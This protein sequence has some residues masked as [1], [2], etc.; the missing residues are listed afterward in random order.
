MGNYFIK[1]ERYVT[2]MMKRVPFVMSEDE[3]EGRLREHFHKEWLPGST[4]P[5]SDAWDD[6]VDNHILSGKEWAVSYT[7]CPCPC[8]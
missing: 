2:Q 3:L 8:L 4:Y 5:H 1:E 6:L 7:C